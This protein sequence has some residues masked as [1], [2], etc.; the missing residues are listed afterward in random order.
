[1][2][3]TVRAALAT[4]VCTGAVAVLCAAESGGALG[5]SALA[6]VGPSPWWTGAAALGWTLLVGVPGAL[7]LRWRPGFALPDADGARVGVDV[8]VDG[9]P[10]DDFTDFTDA[11]FTDA[12]FTDA[13]HPDGGGFRRFSLRASRASSAAWASRWWRRCCRRPE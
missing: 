8:P 4:A 6:R 12:D 13:A 1:V 9:F 7:L 10:E 2:L 11:D 3:A 5:T